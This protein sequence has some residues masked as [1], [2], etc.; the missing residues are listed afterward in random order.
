MPG[1]E[2]WFILRAMGALE[3][4]KQGKD[5]IRALSWKHRL[6]WLLYRGAEEEAGDQ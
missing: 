4:L 2:A 6:S 3:G 1:Q 5:I